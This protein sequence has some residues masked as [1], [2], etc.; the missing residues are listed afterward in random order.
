MVVGSPVTFDTVRTAVVGTSVAPT[1]TQYK[2][3]A[4]GVVEIPVTI[5]NTQFVPQTVSIPA[6]KPVRL[7]VDRKEANACSAQLALPQLGI[8]KNLADNAVTTV[9]VPAAKA[10]AYTL[11]CG[12]GMMSG[13]LVVGGA[14]G[15]SRR[16]LVAAGRAPAFGRRGA[17]PRRAGPAPG[18]PAP[19]PWRRGK[20][21]GNRGRTPERGK[22]QQGEG[23]ENTGEHGEKRIGGHEAPDVQPRG[24]HPVGLPARRDSDRGSLVVMAIIIGLASG[25]FFR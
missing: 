21:P 23:G 4:D 25:G 6:D 13:S 2:T 1:G 9:D 20:E 11:T 14:S 16:R 18:C 24:G 5:Q 12:M 15:G 22:R 7:V 17:A 3:G 19:R 10:G 8:L